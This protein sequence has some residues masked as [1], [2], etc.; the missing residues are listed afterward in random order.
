MLRECINPQVDAALC[1]LAEQATEIDEFLRRAVVQLLAR[2]LMGEQPDACHIDVSGL[3]D[4]PRHLVRELFRELWQRQQW[5][6]QAMG[7]DQWNRLAEILSTR[8][9]ITLPS[10]I[11]ARFHSESLLVLRRL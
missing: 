2:C 6:R 11:E 1:R 3:T 5:P 10:R 4:E 8:E 7:F 9:T